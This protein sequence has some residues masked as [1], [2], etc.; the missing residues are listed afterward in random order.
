MADPYS[1]PFSKKSP[2]TLA[3]KDITSFAAPEKSPQQLDLERAKFLVEQAF[4]ED[5]AD[6]KKEA[7]DLYMQA[8]ELCIKV[9]GTDF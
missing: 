1:S 3:E 5:A 6:N 2:F 9:V 4:D 8:A 7:L